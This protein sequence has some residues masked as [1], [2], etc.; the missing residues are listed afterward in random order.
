LLFGLLLLVSL[1]S[2]DYDPVRNATLWNNVLQKYVTT[3]VTLHGVV[4]NT[5]DYK[6]ISTDADFKAY[7]KS[8]ETANIDGLNK[9]ET[10]AFFMNVYN[11]LAVNMVVVHSCGD[12]IFG[13]CGPIKSIEDIGTILPYSPVWG[14]QAGIVGGKPWSLDDVENYIRKPPAGMTEDSRLHA[15]IVCASVSCPNLRKGA[16][17]IEN[18]D[19]E[20]TDNFNDFLNSTKKGM[21]VDMKEKKVTLSSIFNWYA[22]DFKNSINGEVLDFILKYLHPNTTEFEWLKANKDDVELEYFDYD[23]DVNAKGDLPC[24]KSRPCYPL[25]ALLVTLGGILVVVC[26]ILLAFLI[27]HKLKRKGYFRVDKDIN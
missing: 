18:L 25:W 13:T 1:V 8:L 2:A 20:M 11:A 14:K 7:L 6:G 15:C 12:D 3:G 27:R 17:T 23:W 9:T 26:V 21:S 16:Y 5:V 4:I 19:A 10:Y 22:D 24:D